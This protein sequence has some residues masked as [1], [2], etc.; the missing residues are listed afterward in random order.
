V[1][2]DRGKEIHRPYDLP[3]SL[4]N[5]AYAHTADDFT[6]LDV[7][8]P[9]NYKVVGGYF[10]YMT[11][12]MYPWAIDVYMGSSSDEL[13]LYPAEFVQIQNGYSSFEGWV[14]TWDP[15][16]WYLPEYR[17]PDSLYTKIPE[18]PYEE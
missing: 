10:T 12:A 6:D 16:Y 17:V 4:A 8:L 1:N 13:F 15:Y 5:P 11:E 7:F 3:T 2:Q 9:E 14:E 18:P